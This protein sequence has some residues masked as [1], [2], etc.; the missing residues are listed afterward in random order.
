MTDSPVTHHLRG[1]LSIDQQLALKT[2]ATRLE[3]EFDGTFGVETIERFLHSPY[4]QFAGGATVPN[5]LPLL[6]ERFARQRLNALARVRRRRNGLLAQRGDA[7]PRFLPDAG[8]LQGAWGVIPAH[9]TELPPAFRGCYPGVTY[10]LGN[11][12]AAFNVPIH[13]RL[14][15]SHGYPFALAATIVPVLIA[16]AVLT[17]IGKDGTGIRFGT[18]Q[19]AYRSIGS[20]SW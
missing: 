12:L 9:L 18:E 16:V 8:V 20:R 4:D 17:V 5:F 2:A 11:L 10:Q 13:K 14:A 3:R 19:S 1:N 6:A 7:V 15:E